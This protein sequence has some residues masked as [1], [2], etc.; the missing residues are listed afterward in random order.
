MFMREKH[1]MS[2]LPEYR[3]WAGI[4]Q[5]CLNPKRHDFA[6]Y[7][8][9]GVT[10]CD[11]WAESFSAFFEHIGPRPSKL[12][13]V[14]RIDGT[15]GYSPGNVRWADPY[16]QAANQSHV[17][18]FSYDGRTL[19]ASEWARET[20]IGFTTIIARL[21]RGLSSAEVLAKHKLVGD[22]S[23]PMMIEFKGKSQ[24]ASVWAKSI[25]VSTRTL[26]KRIKAGIPLERALCNPMP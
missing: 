9:A 13:S 23:P 22:S 18:A 24:P 3:I 1:G 15:K 6:R 10:L 16:G 19:T 25:G 7:G 26:K 5:R 20:G 12:H 4:K 11:E 17:R 2:G 21:N 8:G 14:D